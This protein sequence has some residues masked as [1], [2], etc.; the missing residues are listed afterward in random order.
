MKIDDIS[1]NN[2]IDKEEGG[3][4]KVSDVNE[5]IENFGNILK[6]TL[7]KVNEL[8]LNY[9]KMSQRFASGE[10]DNVHDL[11][12]AATRAEMSLNIV[13]QIRNQLLRA[14]NELMRMM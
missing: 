7:N 1:F 2:F 6:D 13:V 8:D 5:N 12:I 9:D 4:R 3:K 14:Y 11:M 10:L